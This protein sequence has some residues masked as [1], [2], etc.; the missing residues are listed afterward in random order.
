MGRVISCGL[1]AVA[2]GENALASPVPELAIAFH[3]HNPLSAKQTDH[4][5]AN[6]Q[7][8]RD[9]M[10]P[11]LNRLLWLGLKRITSVRL[12]PIRTLDRIESQLGDQFVTHFRGAFSKTCEIRHDSILLSEEVQAPQ[13]RHF[14]HSHAHGVVGSGKQSVI[15]HKPTLQSFRPRVP[16]VD[17][18]AGRLP[19]TRVADNREVIPLLDST[20]QFTPSKFSD[21]LLL[22]KV[23]EP[24]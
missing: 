16:L 2:A 14:E 17:F 4:T 21:Q 10:R 23:R 8:R 5:H 13:Q 19:K 3:A 12:L 24:L 9:V 7:P 18:A 22:Q 6:G 11:A 15:D 1:E 20:T